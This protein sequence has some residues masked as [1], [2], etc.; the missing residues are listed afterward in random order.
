M[1][2]GVKDKTVIVTGGAGGLGF[3]A[4]KAFA[5]AGARVAVLDV[6][7]TAIDRATAELG[8]GSIGESVD[9]RDE[10][11]VRAGVAAV[12]RAFGRVDVLF[13]NAGVAGFGSVD[14]TEPAAWQRIFDV[15]VVGTYLMSRA[16]LPGM[17]ARGSGAIVNVGSVAALAGVPKMAAYCAA[18]GAIVSLT[19]QMA[20]EYSGRGVR[21]NCVCPGTVAVTAMGQQLMGSDA[22]PEATARRIAKYPIGR[23]GQPEE[24]AAAVLF[25]ASDQASFVTGSIFAVDGGMTAI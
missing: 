19:R 25:L 5:G 14:D 24:I 17:L 15:N 6:D 3:A 21:V 23:F 16:V 2:E 12:E 8:N 13:N 20:A 4:A 7:R 18:K 9:V 10:A 1:G 11:A 22:T